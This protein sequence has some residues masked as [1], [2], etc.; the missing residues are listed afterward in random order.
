M[1]VSIRSGVSPEAHASVPSRARVTSRAVARRAG[2]LASSLSYRA[3]SRRLR[4]SPA[5][6]TTSPAQSQDEVAVDP[7]A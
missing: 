7:H 1:P 5:P 4:A 6:S 3:E 2:P